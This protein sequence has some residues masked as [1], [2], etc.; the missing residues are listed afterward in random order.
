MRYDRTK[1]SV[2]N[3]AVVASRPNGKFNFL[4]CRCVVV[5]FSAFVAIVRFDSG[6]V[7]VNCAVGVYCC[8]YTLIQCCC[9][10]YLIRLLFLLSLLLS[11]LFVL[12]TCV[13][14][15]CSLVIR[16]FQLL[17]RAPLRCCWNCSC[18]CCCCC[19]SY[20][21]TNRAKLGIM[22]LAPLLAHLIAASTYIHT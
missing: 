2:L 22:S 15:V 3:A 7:A 19:S 9:Y 11:L 8:L 1:V 20:W 21:R 13:W 18:C 16:N 10:T 14:L 12:L 4:P 17:R 6:D 5:A